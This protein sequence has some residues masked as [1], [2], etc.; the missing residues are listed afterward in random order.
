MLI[1]AERPHLTGY[2]FTYMTLINDLPS[3]SGS[4]I[5]RL[6]QVAWP[7]NSVGGDLSRVDG[8]LLK[9]KNLP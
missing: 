3:S 4:D 2:P 1:S 5:Y 6:T 7:D 8:K 9:S